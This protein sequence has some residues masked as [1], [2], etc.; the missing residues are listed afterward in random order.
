M[1]IFGFRSYASTK[2]NTKK[3]LIN[4][5]ERKKPST[6]IINDIRVNILNIAIKF[7]ARH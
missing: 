4:D 7:I 2:N 6:F 3:L 5:M 1:K